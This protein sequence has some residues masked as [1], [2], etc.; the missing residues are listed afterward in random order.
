MKDILAQ[1][2]QANDAGLYYVALFA[3]LA[4]PDICGALESTDGQANGERYAR[5]FDTHVSPRYRAGG[6]TTVTGEDAYRFRC[7]ML[8]QG[9]TSHPQARYSRILFVEPG[10]SGMILHNNVLNGAL[11]ID[12]RIFVTD[13][14]EAVDAWLPSA[15]LTPEYQA[16]RPLFVTRY[17]NGLPPFIA[18]VPVIA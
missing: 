1:I 16:N 10:V 12:V 18:G 7:S 15:E 17:P 9:R 13:I 6:Q 5:W 14:L 2:R 11:N 4:L 3:A 8:H